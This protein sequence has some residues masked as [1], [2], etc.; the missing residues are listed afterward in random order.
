[1]T[2]H[3]H[4]K[5]YKDNS[6]LII[7]PSFLGPLNHCA[8]KRK[9]YIKMKIILASKFIKRMV[10]TTFSYLVLNHRKEAELACTLPKSYQEN[11]SYV[12]CRP[13]LTK[14]EITYLE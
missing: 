13:S 8:F 12:I 2:Y 6:H 1:M 9:K 4:S 14:K 11:A 7:T 10:S 3:N 5:G